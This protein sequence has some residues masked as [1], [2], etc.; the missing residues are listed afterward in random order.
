MAEGHAMGKRKFCSLGRGRFQDKPFSYSL[1]QAFFSLEDSSDGAHQQIQNKLVDTLVAMA[2]S[3][4]RP[5]ILWRSLSKVAK[6]VKSPGYCRSAGITIV[7]VCT[8]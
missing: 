7:A 1:S 4:Q 3:R 6:R 2:L 5:P 8:C